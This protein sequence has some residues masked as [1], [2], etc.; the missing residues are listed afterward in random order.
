MRVFIL[1]SRCCQSDTSS[2]DP[3]RTWRAPPWWQAPARQGS[4]RCS[5]SCWGR[6][7]RC[8]RARGCS[9]TRPP[10]PSCCPPTPTSTSS[11][12]SVGPWAPRTEGNRVST[13]R[14]WSSKPQERLPAGHPRVNRYDKSTY[15]VW[16]V[17]I[18][19]RQRSVILNVMWI[20]IMTQFSGYEGKPK[21]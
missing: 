13:H 11:P 15:G 4:S 1:H 17:L 6:S 14:G 12:R 3:S 8:T 5:W 9:R 7:L 21:P 19:Y 2:P 10:R 20:W 16:T 18:T